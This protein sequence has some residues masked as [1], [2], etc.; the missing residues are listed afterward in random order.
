M[1]TNILKRQEVFRGKI[2]RRETQQLNLTT[3]GRDPRQINE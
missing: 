1:N 3:K 2:S